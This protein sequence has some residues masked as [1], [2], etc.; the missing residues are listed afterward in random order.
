M[1]QASDD[2]REELEPQ[3]RRILALVIVLILLDYLLNVKK[4]VSS[5]HVLPA[6]LYPFIKTIAR[7]LVDIAFV[8]CLLKF[9]RAWFWWLMLLLALLVLL[10]VPKEV[11]EFAT[12]ASSSLIEDSTELYVYCVGWLLCLVLAFYLLKKSSRD[13]CLKARGTP[14]AVSEQ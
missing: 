4:I 14:S 2:E 6:P 13:L 7:V 3:L 10:Y 9:Y 8:Y 12:T 5:I 1:G 11:Y